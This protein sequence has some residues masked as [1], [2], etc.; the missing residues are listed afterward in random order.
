MV[1]EERQGNEGPACERP[2][3]AVARRSL[4]GGCAAPGGTGVFPRSFVSFLSRRWW[5]ALALLLA[6]LGNPV[7]QASSAED[8]EVK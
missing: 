2:D 6:A 5:P 1:Y 7:F 3:E 8:L 4:Q